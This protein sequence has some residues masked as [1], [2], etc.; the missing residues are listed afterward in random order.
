M[1]LT[2]NKTQ[3]INL[4]HDWQPT[5]TPHLQ[6]FRYH[7]VKVSCL[8]LDR[9][10]TCFAPACTISFNYVLGVIFVHVDSRRWGWVQEK[11]QK[12]KLQRLCWRQM[13]NS[14]SLP[15][16]C[17]SGKSVRSSRTYWAKIVLLWAPPDR[18]PS[19]TWT[20][21]DTSHTS[22]N[23]CMLL[24]R[25]IGHFLTVSPVWSLCKLL[26]LPSVD[27]F[28]AALRFGSDR[29]AILERC[30]CA[31]CFLAQTTEEEGTAAC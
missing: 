7:V 29:F 9:H 16:F 17:L 30:S 25:L 1:I 10:W 28:A 22:G 27:G 20:S 15:P 2:L 13:V 19:W 18:P 24:Y 14:R 23:T 26:E 6:N 4:D 3:N 8:F 12:H 11:H 31:V 21:R 5:L